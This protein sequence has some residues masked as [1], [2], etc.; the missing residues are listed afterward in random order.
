MNRKTVFSILAVILTVTSLD[1]TGCGSLDD[2]SQPEFNNQ[3][4][5]ELIS[6]EKLNVGDKKTVEVHITDADLDDTHTITAFSDDTSVVTASIDEEALTIRGKAAGM[7]TVTVTATDDSGQDNAMSAPVTFQ[8]SVNEPPPSVQI[9]IGINQPL[10]YIDKGA[11]T[12][13]MSLKPG[14]GC[15]YDS[16]NPFAEIIFSVRQD[17]TACREEVPDTWGFGEELQIPERF[18]P[19]NL[20]LC[21]EWN[22][23]R[24]NFFDTDFAASKNHD[25]SWTVRNVP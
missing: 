1:L 24:D 16:N 3:P 7:V 17:G 19:R 22:I 9:G 11:C 15:S 2:D 25:G 20:R 13:G 8:V 21:V 4:E 12:V 6:D 10:S 14:E 18:E 5:I 23:G